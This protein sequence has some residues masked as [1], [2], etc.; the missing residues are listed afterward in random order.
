MFIISYFIIFSTFETL[1]A[2]L[3]NISNRIL[4]MFFCELAWSLASILI[5]KRS[6][7]IMDEIYL[8][9]QDMDGRLTYHFHGFFFILHFPAQICVTWALVSI[10]VFF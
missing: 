10:Q 4:E 1:H 7:V 5:V 3:L 8:L 2:S 9:F 6:R